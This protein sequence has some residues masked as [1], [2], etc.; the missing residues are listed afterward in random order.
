MDGISHVRAALWE[1]LHQAET[2][3]AENTGLLWKRSVW[4][5]RERNG[6]KEWS[7]EVEQSVQEENRGEE[8]NPAGEKKITDFV[9]GNYCV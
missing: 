1:F 9:N 2:E 8:Q 7:K 3:A 6:N 4:A 5:E